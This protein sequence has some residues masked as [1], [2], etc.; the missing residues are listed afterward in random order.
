MNLAQLDLNL[1]VTLDALLE[2][3][4]V[5][6]AARRIGLSQPAVSNALARL[7]ETLGDPLMVRRGSVM[8]PTP[9]AI[10]IQSQLRQALQAV[11]RVITPPR[12]FDPA[13]A[14]DRL[15]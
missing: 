6:R 13:T 5:T 12:P 15:N 11:E 9:R 1:L 8:V 7:R 2:E 3:R 4:S 14:R 10:E